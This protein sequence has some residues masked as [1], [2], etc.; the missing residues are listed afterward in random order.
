LVAYQHPAGLNPLQRF[1]QAG[2]ILRGT[3][4]ASNPAWYR[5]AL[6]LDFQLHLRVD[7]NQVISRFL[8]VRTGT[9]SQGPALD[10]SFATDLSLAPAFAGEIVAAAQKAGAQSIG[11][12]LHVA[13]EFATSELKPELDN[14]GALVELR[15]TIETDPLAVLDDSSVSAT[16]SSWR[17]IPYP[18]GGSD[19]IA[20]TVCLSRRWAPFLDELRSHGQQKNYPVI[21]RA[22]SAPLVAL[23]ALPALKNDDLAHPLIAVLPYPRFTLLAFF[24]EHGDLLLLRTLQH[25]GQRRPT[26]L[27]HAASTTAAALEL[28]DPEVFLLSGESADPQL[29]A[30][31]QLVFPA[32]PIREIDWT[33]APFELQ[34]HSQGAPEARIATLADG[35]ITSPLASSH[36]FSVLRAD[37]WAFQDFLPVAKEAAEIF[38]SRGEMK[39]L[40]SARFAILGFACMTLLGLAWTGLQMIDMVRKP[41]WAF[42]PASAQT[43]QQRLGFL[44][45][46]RNRMEHW[47]NMLEDRSKAWTTMELIAILFPGDSG[48]HVKTFNH[49]VQPQNAPGQKKVGFV[50]EWKITGL[51]R[52]DALERLNLMNT[53]EG[54]TGIFNEVAKATGDKSF[55]TDLDTRSLVVNVRTLENGT[56]RPGPVDESAVMDESTYPL[57]F[58]L[59]IS[60]RFE[61]SDVMALTAAQAP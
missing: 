60:Q 35:V 46:E 37:G 40:R 49:S 33:V 27:R 17:L 19:A 1:R 42:D 38:P 58:D 57:T 28:A 32:S 12:V 30:D 16:E 31:L 25:R 22:I 18:A 48:F 44:T 5:S 52:E 34:N 26:N 55:Q 9:W 23:L 29:A 41:E 21:T 47:D 4:R 56:Y 45:T 2:A 13:D 59:T 11:V 3:S 8:D 24:N 7:G 61:S 6:D 14:P 50:R 15:A 51:A 20:T 53:R 36:T 43:Q 10:D 39:L 54:I